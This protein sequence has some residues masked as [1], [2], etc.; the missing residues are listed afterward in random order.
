MKRASIGILVWAVFC[1]TA[2][3]QSA[4]STA[5][6]APT[7]DGG[8]LKLVRTIRDP[9]LKGPIVWL[10]AGQEADILY[11]GCRSAVR[12][13]LA[14][15]KAEAELTVPINSQR[16]DDGVR[17][18]DL[19]PDGKTLLVLPMANPSTRV[20][21]PKTMQTRQFVEAAHRFDPSGRGP[22][23]V[24]ID[25]WI[26]CDEGNRLA[27][28]GNSQSPD[29]RRPVLYDLAKKEW[30]PIR[31]GEYADI[32]P[33]GKPGIA[34][35]PVLKGGGRK[36]AF[37]NSITAEEILRF[38]AEITPPATASEWVFDQMP[39]AFAKDNRLMLLPTKHALRVYR[40][41]EAH[42]DVPEKA[43]ETV[44]LGNRRVWKIAFHPDGVHWAML[45]AID[46]TK[47]A[48]IGTREVTAQGFAALKFQK[49]DRVPGCLA[50]SADGKSLYVGNDD[51]SIGVYQ[52][53]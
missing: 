21:E 13:N 44:D 41:T 50:F 14:T 1:G 46:A 24:A 36:L 30:T 48:Q 7:A 2:R 25:R 49:V 28:V 37:W 34:L 10:T 27:T 9:A 20:V 6:V 26:W 53:P 45:A 4:G 17:M 43:G 33:T 51:A 19:S 42:P 11:V 22:S 38:D 39:V 18:M 12:W 5:A 8:G 40:P 31:E 15:G 35:S 29:I 16:P 52:W 23:D 32:L 3:A 47:E